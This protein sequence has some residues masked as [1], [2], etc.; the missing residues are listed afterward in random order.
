MMSDQIGQKIEIKD[1]SGKYQ[2]STERIE[3]LNNSYIWTKTMKFVRS[4]GESIPKSPYKIEADIHCKACYNWA[5][6]PQRVKFKRV[7]KYERKRVTKY[8][9]ACE[10]CGYLNAED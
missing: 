6:S 8:G 10:A 3:R 9:Y 2:N 4:T 7:D 5:L 1:S